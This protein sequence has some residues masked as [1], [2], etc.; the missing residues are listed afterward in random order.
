MLSLPRSR[1]MLRLRV[2]R[3]MLRA[4]VVHRGTVTWAGETE[5]ADLAELADAIARLAAEPSRPCRRLVVALERPPVQLRTLEGLP[6]VSPQALAALVAHQAGRFFRKNG[7]ALATD[8]VWVGNAATRVARAAAVEEQVVEA[9]G[10][11]ARAAGLVL[12]TIAPAGEAVPLALLPTAERAARERAERRLVRQLAIGAAAVWLAAGVLFMARLGWE[13]RAVER[14]LAALGGPLGAVLAARRELREAEAT[15]RGVTQRERTR[16]RTL[17]LLAVI[18]SSLPDSAV[19]TSLS[20]RADGT[21]VLSGSAR[22]AA[23]VVARVERAEPLAVPRLEGPVVRETIGGR[24]WERF[25][26]VFGGSGLGTRG[27]GGAPR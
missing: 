24:E 15:V 25:T 11:G 9:I 17:I 14:E 4:E 23:D 5:Y 6:P 21:G 2:G 3:D 1:G 10:A 20:W 26:I 13:R 18:A 16:G 27:S 12:E 8:A 22:R 7:Q 19:I